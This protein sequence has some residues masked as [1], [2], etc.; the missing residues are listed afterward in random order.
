MVNSIRLFKNYITS[1][2]NCENP[3]V[4]LED[5]IKSIIINGKFIGSEIIISLIYFDRFH[6]NKLTEVNE[7]NVGIVFAI[8]LLL[9]E[10]WLSDYDLIITEWP[11]LLKISFDELKLLEI[12]YLFKQNWNMHITKEEYKEKY[13]YLQTKKKEFLENVYKENKSNTFYSDNSIDNWLST[14]LFENKKHSN[15]LLSD[16]LFGIINKYPLNLLVK[17]KRCCFY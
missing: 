15:I 8:S 2:D 13:Q 16:I 17:R 14:D 1:F 10:K 6:K 11:I 3:I 9:A 12:E 4:N 5:F 7:N